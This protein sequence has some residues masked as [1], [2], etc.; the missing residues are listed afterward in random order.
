MN[1]T[2]FIVLVFWSTVYLIH[3]LL[4]NLKQTSLKYAKFLHKTGF[5]INLFQIK[6]FTVKLNRLFI[7]LSTNINE[8]FLKVWF[9]IG[10]VIGILGQLLSVMLLIYNIIEFLSRIFVLE[11]NRVDSNDEQLL[12]PIIPGVN[13]PSSQFFYYFLTLF[14]SGLVHE[15][16]HAIAATSNN[17]RVNGFGLFIIFV[18]PGAF[19][20]LNSD[21]VNYVNNVK[22]LRIFCAGIWHVIF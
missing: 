14:L 22:K 4:L 9:N 20:D 19:V 2:I 21:H 10:V 12:V 16:G 15:F 11:E 1:Q 6:W 13:L 5:S 17:V 3:S 8:N 7:K 18:F